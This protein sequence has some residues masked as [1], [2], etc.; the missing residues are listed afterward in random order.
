M[1]NDEN[2]KPE[3]QLPEWPRSGSLLA[4]DPNQRRAQNKGLAALEAMAGIWASE[5]ALS[6]IARLI[7]NIE[8]PIARALQIG[9]IT[10]QGFIEGAYRHYLDCTE[11]ARAA[12]QERDYP[13]TLYR[14][15]QR[16]WCE[17]FERE[18]GFEPML[19]EYESGEKTF[20]E[21]AKFDIEWYE[22]H[23]SDVFLQVSDDVP[24]HDLEDAP[25]P[26]AGIRRE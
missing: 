16:E 19:D 6:R 13:E 1:P 10:E 24:G 22:S 2:E 4:P 17:K 9:R 23:S 3:D 11:P 25:T 15:K 26:P 14:P 21:I 8:D 18:T 5:I 20:P 7:A 12:Y